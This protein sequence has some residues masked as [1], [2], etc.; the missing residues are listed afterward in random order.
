MVRAALPH[1]AELARVT[2]VS[3]LQTRML[4]DRHKICPLNESP[5]L[6]WFYRS[7]C[8]SLVVMEV[9]RGVGVKIDTEM[10]CVWKITRRSRETCLSSL[11]SDA[12]G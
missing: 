12:C 1:S 3:C 8:S 7:W 10:Q 2:Q 5:R 11:S 6:A 9:S 4:L